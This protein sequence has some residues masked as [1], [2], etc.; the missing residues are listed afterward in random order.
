MSD[1]GSVSEHSDS[2]PH[3]EICFR[4]EATG[5]DK[6]D[7]FLRRD[8]FGKAKF[9]NGDTYEGNYVGGKRSGH[10]V[11]CFANGSKYE[12]EY[13]EGL[14]HGRGTF[15]APDKSIYSG[16]YQLDQREGAG[17]YTYPNGDQYVG[18]WR[19]NQKH[20]SGEYLYADGGKGKGNRFVGEWSN[21]K[22]VYGEWRWKSGTK[23]IGKF[24]QNRPAGSGLLVTQAGNRQKGE[25][26]GVTKE[27][28]P[29]TKFATLQPGNPT[30]FTVALREVEKS[31]LKFDQFE[32][33]Y[34]LKKDLEGAPNSR[35]VGETNVFACGQPTVQAIRLLH[36]QI[37]EAGFDS[38]LSVN[39]RPEPVLYIGD[40]PF[41]ARSAHSLNTPFSFL[42]LNADELNELETQWM[43]RMK[44][45]IS[46][47]GFLYQY[48]K[49][50]YAELPADRQNIEV[51]GEIKKLEEIQSLQRV[52]EALKEENDAITLQRISIDEDRSPSLSAFDQFVRLLSDLPPTQ[53]LVFTDQFGK[54][55]VTTAAVI[56]TLI[57]KAAQEE[58]EPE[59]EPEAENEN[60]NEN[61]DEPEQEE[62]N[63]ED[64]EEQDEEEEEREAEEEEEAEE[65][66]STEEAEANKQD[67]K[68]EE[69]QESAESA[70][71][72]AEVDAD[73]EAEEAEPEPVNYR[74]GQ[75]FVITQLVQMLPK[76]AQVKAEVDDAVD[77]SAAMLNLRENIL[78]A[79]EQFD[80]ESDEARKEEW[81]ELGRSGL[82]RYFFLIA[83]HAY[84]KEQRIKAA[85]A[86][87]E[88]S[89]NEEK[90]FPLPS[91]FTGWVETNPALFALLG[92]RNGGAL[93][94]FNWS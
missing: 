22:L 51:K 28:K 11:Y 94:E 53:A 49:D 70:G 77:K 68:A 82:E 69:N 30:A 34:R 5:E 64:E 73:E 47:R 14:R 67:A 39:L 93:K 88:E 29:N 59:P 62:E 23:F 32:G 52:Y 15:Q 17:T 7:K 10:G 78:F 80:K 4:D 86:A 83:F 27:W 76:G 63:Q 85:K 56:A 8:G 38:I 44:S 58:V 79:K 45:Q 2:D 87:Q 91:T 92:T 46:S 55:R 84:L 19:S 40:F 20:G 71:G 31:V 35:R 74:A 65:E 24:R 9:A 26:D 41:S 75:Y 3:Y 89:D 33:I 16:Y 90:P 21:G 57:Q 25:F 42:A 66:K 81:K 13:S 12:G 72:S 1:R 6:T 48:H 54:G 18:Q 43:K 61:E 50:A 60:E 37:S 36:E